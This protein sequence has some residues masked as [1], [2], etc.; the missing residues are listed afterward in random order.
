MTTLSQNS[1]HCDDD[2]YNKILE[3]PERPHGS[4]DTDKVYHHH[5]GCRI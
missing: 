1:D 5:A 3:G 2:A 4:H